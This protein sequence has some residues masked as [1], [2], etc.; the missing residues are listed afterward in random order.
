MI[1]KPKNDFNATQSHLEALNHRLVE[2]LGDD[3]AIN[4]DEPEDFE[5]EGEPFDRYKIRCVY[6]TH[7]DK[8]YDEDPSGWIGVSQSDSNRLISG[9]WVCKRLQVIKRPDGYQPAPTLRTLSHNDPHLLEVLV[10]FGCKEVV[11]K[12][13]E[14]EKPA[15]AFPVTYADGS[16]G[17]HYRVALEGRNKWL[18]KEGGKAGEAVF[19]L[20]RKGIQAGIQKK[21]FVI[22]TES[23][24]DALVL[25]AA[26]NPAIAVLGKGN[27]D[28]L[29]CDLHRETLLNLLGDAG[30]IYVW[31]EPDAPEF[32]RKVAN[33][34]QRPVKVISPPVP[35]DDPK[36][37][38]D[39][40]RLWVK[41]CGKDWEKFKATINEL[42]ENATEVAAP[43][44]EPVQ[45]TKPQTNGRKVEIP[46]TIFKRLGDIKVQEV[47]WLIDEYIPIGAVTLLAGE[48]GAGKSSLLCDLTA[49][50]LKGDKWLG[51]FEVSQ[52]GVILILTEGVEEIR[53]RL[54]CY[55]ITDDNPLEIV[56]LTAWED[57]E[58]LEVARA[59]PEILQIAKERL[60]ERFG[61]IP[62]RLV[63]LDCLRG[64]G[65][66]ETKASRQKSDKLPTV[67][68]IYKP[69]AEFAKEE[70]S[71]VIVTHHSR[72]P[73][74]EE[75]RRLYPKRKKG[76]EVAPDIDI[77]LLRNLIAGTADIVNAARHAL[78]VVSDLEAGLGIIVPVKSNRSQVLGA[79]I[80]YDF[81]AETPTFIEFLDEGE[82]AIETAIAFL[83][84]VLSKG[85]IP[86][87]ELEALAKKEGIS[88]RTYWRARKRLGVKAKWVYVD[89]KQVWIAYLPNQANQSDQ[90]PHSLPN[91]D[92]QVAQPE[93]TGNPTDEPDPQGSPT[94]RPAG[95]GNPNF[96][97]LGSLSEKPKQNLG[98]YSLPTEKAFGRLG[99][100]GREPAS[101]AVCQV[102]QT[103]N[104][105]QTTLADCKSPINIGIS[106]QV[107]QDCQTSGNLEIQPE[108]DPQATRPEPAGSPTEPT[109]PVS[110][111]LATVEVWDYDRVY[112]DLPD[113]ESPTNL[114]PVGDLLPCAQAQ[115]EVS[116]P[117]MPVSE[118]KGDLQA[119]QPTG[120]PQEAPPD[121]EPKIE[122]IRINSISAQPEPDSEPEGDQP[123]EDA[124][125]A[126]PVATLNE[127]ICPVCCERLEPE[128]VSGLAAC[129]GCGRLFKVET[130]PASPKGQSGFA[131]PEPAGSPQGSP[132]GDLIPP[133]QPA[134]EP[135]VSPT[136]QSGLAACV[137]VA[138]L[139]EPEGSQPEKET[140]RPEGDLNEEE[141]WGWFSPER[142][143]PSARANL[144]E[145]PEPTENP[146]EP[147]PQATE[148]LP[149][150]E[151]NPQPDRPAGSPTERPVNDPLATETEPDPQGSPT[152]RP[153][154]CPPAMPD[155]EPEIEFIRINSIS[156]QPEPEGDQPTED[157]LPAQPV[158][159][160][161]EPICPICGI[162]L[163][164]EPVSGLAACLG[165]GRLFKVEIPPTSPV[166]DDGGDNPPDD[167]DNPPDEPDGGDGGNPPETPNNGHGSSQI[168]FAPPKDFAIPPAFQPKRIADKFVSPAILN[169]MTVRQPDGSIKLEWEDTT[170]TVAPHDLAGWQPIEDI[171]DIDLPNIESVEIPPVVVLDIETTDKDP[172]RGR[173]LA[174]GL[175]LY[176]EGKEVETLTID[177]DNG[178]RNLLIEVFD[179][180]RATCDR[181]GKI[182]LTGYNLFDFDLTYLIERARKLKVKCPFR[183][184]TNENGEIKRWQVAT[185]KG[186]LKNED[187]DYNA[188]VVDRN[189]PIYIVD[190]LHLVCRWDYTAKQL[191]HYDLKSVAEH[192]EVNIP[193]RPVLSHKEIVHAYYH[194]R[195]KFN[196]YLLADL[197]ETYAVFAKLIPPYLGIAALTWL[198]LDQVVT[199][200][201][202]W[203]WQ[204]I[205]QRH[206]N[207]KPQADEKQKY[208]GGLVVSRKGLWSPC[209]KLDIASLYP[210]IMLAYRIHSR[211]DPDQ[212]ALRWLKTLTEQRLA[213]KAKARAGDANAQIKQEAMKILLNSLYGF[214]GTEG[215]GFNDMDAAEKVT[216]I[217]RKVLTRMVA[218]IE[219][220]GGIIVEADTDGL[221][222]CYRNAD[223]QEILKAV[224]E[225]I[226]EVFKVETEWQDATVFVSDD[227]NYIVLDRNGDI[228]TVKGG[229]WRGRDKPA[230]A[231]KAIPDFLQLWVTKGKEAALEYARKIWAEIRC[232]QG[233]DWVV[234]THRVGE[235][236]ENFIR[237]GFEVGERAVFAYKVRAKKAKDSEIAKS[238][239]EGY[240]CDYYAAK[241][242]K[243]VKEV[244]EVID[245]A[246][247]EAWERMVASEARPLI[248]ATN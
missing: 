248:F 221:I 82:T 123:T 44:P 1:V 83:R 240:D 72:K 11:I 8:H 79:P 29:A 163:E 105:W 168:G 65:F 150:N 244:I 182:V 145:R 22:V 190:T 112:G 202:A 68:E 247:I 119:T 205:L 47:E 203:I 118:P 129:L 86:S 116:P 63:V 196:A 233:W 235:D 55:G 222:V 60:Q 157:A 137:V 4:L 187:L 234:E 160:L 142:L 117:A 224:S 5:L 70:G 43:Q 238:P 93:P 193:D 121:S 230:F 191:I 100:V 6:Y 180:L 124:L 74:A 95:D 107:C 35:E 195:P 125:P 176:V 217:G 41:C 174:A 140:D 185:T 36:A 159:T 204:Q 57:Y 109:E 88:N 144:R 108:G 148:A 210:T 226:P 146:T 42:L 139:T 239:E 219:D 104:D 46:E 38:K 241:F 32:A 212:I 216:A 12:V 78:V 208:K 128:P 51:K 172:Q 97:S 15:V 89:G 48:G 201:T 120:D 227:K 200:G 141:L 127:P 111:P 64:F 220:K 28:A 85:E 26:G 209:L 96:G 39:A 223:P 211:K 166:G 169:R 184:V 30:T 13:K 245:P 18:H 25:I 173:I 147:N 175:A 155:S 242:S 99:S 20:H 53:N 136:D 152:N 153:Q 19:A 122:F 167:D 236:D 178:E 94:N 77:N 62:I 103:Q 59:L 110:D 161:N 31:L 81:Y 132:E 54:D 33:A 113:D 188:I 9:C 14:K 131:P 130:P 149:T 165:C 21:R 232:G 66:D 164:P 80:R 61:D 246:Q 207:E 194:D 73:T 3:Y 84:R 91:S 192:F 52:G 243:T 17:Y 24:L 170:E 92:T 171:P 198:P 138:T 90:Q 49:A 213:L 197:R 106:E 177:S 133:D 10:A 101:V 206:Y 237:A 102:C 199:K 67:R 126:Q 23:P 134:N 27:A 87:N 218:A 16:Q 114:E 181:L 7:N 58:S 225:A 135:E 115:S 34:L 40:K 2:L 186:T 45:P 228:E 183:F 179:Y 98:F 229:K 151:P 71:A 56:D 215:Y 214:Y 143:K 69:L 162:E 154:G 189:L 37:L 156:T 231:R 158:A 50:I 75:M 76:K